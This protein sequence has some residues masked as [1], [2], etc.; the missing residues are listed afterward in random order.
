VSTA[1]RPF[2]PEAEADTYKG[3][4]FWLSQLGF[5]SYAEYLASPLWQAVRAKVMRK[6]KG[7][8][9]C[10]RGW[11]TQVHHSRYH[12]NDLTGKNTKFLHA[13][14]DTCH[15]SAEFT[16]RSGKKTDVRQANSRLAFMAAK[17]DDGMGIMEKAKSTHE[18]LN[19][20]FDAI[21]R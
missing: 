10:C 11:A 6:S 14:C 4:A 2:N 8:C 3:R 16:W 7:R 19:T 1:D 12:K 21:F 20:E 13:V 17:R 9:C 5:A 18:Q 15:H